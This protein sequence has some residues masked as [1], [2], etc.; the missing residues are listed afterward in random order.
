MALI[1]ASPP[2]IA[3]LHY[4]APPVVGGVEAVIAEHARLFVNAGYPTTIVVG[5]AGTSGFPE[6]V[7]VKVIPEIDSEYPA[8]LAVAEALER[9]EVTSTFAK[10]Q[11]Q[12]EEWL[13]EILAD[14]EIVFAHNV[15]TCHFNMPLLSALHRQLD[16]GKLR[17]LVVW[18]HDLSRYVNP[19]SGVPQRFGFPWDL[20]RTYRPEVTYAAVSEQRRHQMADI[21]G[22]PI[23]R[24]RVVPNGVD[25]ATLLGLSDFGQQ[26][27]EAYHLLET[28]LMILMPIRITRAKNIEFALHVTAA[29]KRG[30]LRPK[31]V[32]TGPPDPHVV[33]ISVY[34]DELCALRKELGLEE[35]AIFVYEGTSGLPRPQILNFSG[36]AEL[37]RLCDLVLMPSH[38]EGFGMPVL[39]SGLVGRPIFV[40]EAVPIVNELGESL[41]HR[42]E[43]DELPEAVANRILELV[44]LEPTSILRRRVRQTYTWTAIFTQSI[45][46]LIQSLVVTSDIH[47]SK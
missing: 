38:R 43:K 37:Y 14:I 9:G 41:V 19:L 36:V 5:R 26:L 29:L 17:H 1:E 16:Q 22:C 20:L 2:R 23:E 39:E 47:E 11:D 40:A 12:I 30:G 28:D 3:L 13:A 8:N 10:L 18:C 15:M 27:V 32:V 35:E 24:I 25:F 31:L 42:I 21:F 4:T 34:F 46:P 6:A 33:D 7:T 44:G 45:E